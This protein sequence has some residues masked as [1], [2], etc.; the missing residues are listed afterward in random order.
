MTTIEWTDETRNPVV[1]LSGS[2]G[3]AIKN[4]DD[5][6]ADLRIREYPT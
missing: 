5:F 1:G 6:P 2:G 4:I 3:H